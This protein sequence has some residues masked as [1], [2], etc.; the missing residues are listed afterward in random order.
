MQS[1]Q[2]PNQTLFFQAGPPNIALR[3][4]FLLSREVC[5]RS[6]GGARAGCPARLRT[7]RGHVA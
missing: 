1:G 6:A 7:V 4:V 5:R 3:D 2:M